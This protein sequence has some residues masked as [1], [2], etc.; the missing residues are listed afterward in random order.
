MIDFNSRPQTAIM[1]QHM[2]GTNF[3]SV[4]LRHV[5]K[6]WQKG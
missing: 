6:P 5:A 1:F 3:I 4:D 2:A